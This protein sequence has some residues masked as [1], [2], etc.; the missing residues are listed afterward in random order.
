VLVTAD[1][2]EH[3]KPSPD[4]F[5]EA[6]KRLGVEPTRCLVVEDA[7]AGLV[8]ARAAGCFTLAVQ[9]TTPVDELDADAI[10]ANLADVTFVF[11]A[12]GIRVTLR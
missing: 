11:R 8:A 10:V 2:V 5:L 9:T 4:P 3:G 7:P 6:A 12:D 1:D